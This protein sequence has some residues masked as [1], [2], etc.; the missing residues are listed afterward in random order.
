METVDLN[1]FLAGL[2]G[3]L[4]MGFLF[5]SPSSFGFEAQQQAVYDRED[6]F[7]LRFEEVGPSNATLRPFGVRVGVPSRSSRDLLFVSAEAF[8]DLLSLV[9]NCRTVGKPGS[10]ANTQFRMELAFLR[11]D[12]TAITACPVSAS[13]FAQIVAKLERAFEDRDQPVPAWLTTLGRVCGEGVNAT[14]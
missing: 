3:A 2:R 14:P 8:K 11:S 6:V 9:Q 5:C 12:G 7:E 10:A 13:V 1:G 4:L